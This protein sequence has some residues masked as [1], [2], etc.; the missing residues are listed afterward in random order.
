MLDSFKS[1][2]L[3]SVIELICLPFKK[4]ILLHE[5]EVEIQITCSTSW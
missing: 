2:T 5:V 4:C 3:Y 1:K